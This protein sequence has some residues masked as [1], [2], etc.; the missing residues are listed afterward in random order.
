MFKA[1]TYT[2]SLSSSCMKYRRMSFGIL[3]YVT[4]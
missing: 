1:I 2:L 4:K 3:L